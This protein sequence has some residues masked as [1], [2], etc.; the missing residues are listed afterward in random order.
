MTDTVDLAQLDKALRKELGVPPAAWLRDAGP[1]TI[2]VRIGD[3]LDALASATAEGDGR[4][5]VQAEGQLTFVG[6]GITAR[7][8][9]W[10]A[11]CTVPRPPAAKAK[12]SRRRV[13]FDP[14][15]GGAA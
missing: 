5:V 15:D 11:A 8:M 9:L 3:N 2:E 4:W 14:Y 10:Q 1:S 12:P 6:D 7:R 13:G